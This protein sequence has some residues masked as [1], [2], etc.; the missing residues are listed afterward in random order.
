ME[1]Y[2]S[3]TEVTFKVVSWAEKPTEKIVYSSSQM[4]P[5]IE[6]KCRIPSL[7]A[8][9]AGSSRQQ[10]PTRENG[11]ITSLRGAESRNLQTEVNM[12]GSLR[13]D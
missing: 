6:A 9:W 3:K 10:L 12:L 4:V 5:T 11:R 8:G 7:R 2:T 13:K 1:K